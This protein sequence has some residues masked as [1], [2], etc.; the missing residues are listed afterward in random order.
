M[1][2]RARPPKDVWLLGSSGALAWAES[3][4]YG[5]RMDPAGLSSGE[6]AH[7]LNIE[8]LGK[9]LEWMSELEVGVLSMRHG[10]TDGIPQPVAGIAR[11]YGVSTAR[12]YQIESKALKKV[13]RLLSE[14]SDPT[15]PPSP[16]ESE[17]SPQI[18]RAADLGFDWD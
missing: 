12:I 7:A 5:A 6:S 11:I 14:P 9:V 18:L 17:S 1:P 2:C 4:R 8:E 15:P 3:P 13:R 10:F 16:S